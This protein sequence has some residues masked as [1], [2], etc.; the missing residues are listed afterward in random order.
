MS[1]SS[2]SMPE[3]RAE[4]KTPSETGGVLVVLERCCGYCAK[5]IPVPRRED[6][7]TFRMRRALAIG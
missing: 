6:F 7:L 5:E 4:Q 1:I 2:V 3:E